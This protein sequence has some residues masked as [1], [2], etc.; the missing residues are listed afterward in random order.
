M[1]LSFIRGSDWPIANMTIVAVFIPNPP[2]IFGR[3]NFSAYF[4]PFSKQH[5]P[6]FVCRLA[7]FY[8]FNR[9]M[10]RSSKLTAEERAVRK[11]E[12]NRV[13]RLDPERLAKKR[14]RDRVR[15]QR[16]RQARL[17]SHDPLALL[18]DTATQAR[19]LEEIGYDDD[20]GE[21]SGEISASVSIPECTEVGTGS[22]EDEGMLIQLHSD[23][24]G[25]S[26]IDNCADSRKS[27]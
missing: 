14:E 18:A 24:E 5:P 17:T 23:E 21:P 9:V 8:N 7:P 4:S 15:Q 20:G 3:Q 10:A 2:K 16:H 6:I 26:L 12:R 13:S 27:S 25:R 1:S 19:L 22:L 11:R